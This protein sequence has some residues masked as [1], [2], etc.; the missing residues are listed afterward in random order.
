MEVQRTPEECF[1][2]LPGWPY[3]PHYTEVE[4]GDGSGTLLRV[5]QGA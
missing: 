5:A 2:G 4:A 3:L 1:E